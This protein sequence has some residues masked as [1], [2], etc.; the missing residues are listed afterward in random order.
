MKHNTAE[1][2]IQVIVMSVIGALLTTSLISCSPAPEDKSR[3]WS[4]Y[5]TPFKLLSRGNAIY[6]SGSYV[7]YKG[8]SFILTNRHICEAGI[9]YNKNQ[10]HIQVDKSI[11][12]VIAIA[13]YGEGDL[14]ILE[15]DKPGF[16][17][18]VSSLEASP[19]DKITLI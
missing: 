6:G 18:K 8:K 9:K 16:G 7:V 4:K 19:L 11:H 10:T 12:K 3:V 1:R 14:C 15:S 13:P 5:A 2:V 17:L